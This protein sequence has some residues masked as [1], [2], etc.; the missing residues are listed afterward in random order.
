VCTFW[1]FDPLLYRDYYRRDIIS[2]PRWRLD[3]VGLWPCELSLQQ[4]EGNHIPCL[5]A[6][7]QFRHSGKYLISISS[8][9][10]LS[11]KRK[12]SKPEGKGQTWYDPIMR[13]PRIILDVELHHTI[14]RMSNQEQRNA[15]C[16]TWP[17]RKSFETD[18]LKCRGAS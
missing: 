9:V 17:H 1:D 8:L 11:K 15:N 10:F 7:L 3:P 6:R 16:V 4:Y 14:R 18:V 5:D 13:L 2:S 12:A